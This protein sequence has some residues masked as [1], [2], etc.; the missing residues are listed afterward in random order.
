MDQS[1]TFTR[2]KIRPKNIAEN[3]SEKLNIARSPPEVRESKEFEIK[4]GGIGPALPG[5]ERTQQGQPDTEY[6]HGKCFIEHAKG[7]GFVTHEC[8]HTPEGMA[9]YN[10][11]RM[12]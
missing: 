7:A 3:A 4:R 11:W 12:R 2:N 9:A 10:N 1:H 5:D 8:F 6:G